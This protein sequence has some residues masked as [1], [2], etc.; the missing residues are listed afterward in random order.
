MK[1]VLLNIGDFQ[2]QSYGAMAAIGFLIAVIWCS[3]NGQKKGYPRNQMIDFC[4]ACILAAIIG[5]RIG[6]VIVEWPSYINNPLDILNVRQGGL[7]WYTGLIG[8]FIGGTFYVRWKK[9]DFWWMADTIMVSVC[10]SH[11]LGRIGCYLYGCCYGMAIESSHSLYWMAVR[12]PGHTV[13][14][15]PIQLISS[16]S[17]LI[18]C[19]VLI[20][21]YSKNI[22]RGTVF[23]FYI[24][25]Y[26]LLRCILEFFRADPRGEFLSLPISTS[27]GIGILAILSAI[28]LY[29]LRPTEK[30]TT[31]SPMSL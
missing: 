12:F 27:Q 31:E 2:V 7:V 16:F 18:I 25:G 14:R 3:Y 5:A 19:F 29:L 1:P 28:G 22:R 20:Y 15:L 30:Q 10:F 11:V 9:L 6:Y 21:L 13:D 8:G 26:G 4:I 23:V 17:L 24:G